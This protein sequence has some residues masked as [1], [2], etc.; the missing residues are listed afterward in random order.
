MR[1]TFKSLTDTKTK[2]HEA[3]KYA[4]KILKLAD[5]RVFICNHLD[6][7]FYFHGHKRAPSYSAKYFPELLKRKPKDVKVGDAWFR[8][9]E[10]TKRLKVLKDCIKETKP[11]AKKNERRIKK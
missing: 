9:Y 1:T 5:S 6:S 8:W 2:R 11:K 3:Y 7:F 10:V 4:Y